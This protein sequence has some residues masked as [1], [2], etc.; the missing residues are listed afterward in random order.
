MMYVTQELK[1]LYHLVEHE[2]LPLDLASKVQPLLEKN[3][4][5]RGKISSASS[6][7]EVQLSL[8]VPALKKL[9][10]MI[11]LQQISKGGMMYVTQE[12]KDLYH[13]LEHEFLPLDLASK[14]QPLLEKNSTVRGKISSASS[15]PEVQLSQYVPAL[16]KLATLILLQQHEPGHFLVAYLLGVLPKRYRVPTMDDLN[17]DELARGRVDFLGLLEENTNQ[18]TYCNPSGFS[19]YEEEKQRIA[20]I[21][22]SAPKSDV[23]VPV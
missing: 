1:D 4:T 2:F 16:K 3:S 17:Q 23:S 19:Q 15:V 13:L 21:E 8:Y 14:V 22:T 7:P 10:T 12:V 18:S 20:L 6:V 9:A 5:V 11:L